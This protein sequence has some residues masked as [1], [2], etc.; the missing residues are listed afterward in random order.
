MYARL[1]LVSLSLDVLAHKICRVHLAVG[2]NGG[3]LCDL[4]HREEVLVS[5]VGSS[6]P[7]SAAVRDYLLLPSV[8]GLMHSLMSAVIKVSAVAS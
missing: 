7:L 8:V 1:F 2:R 4:G 5:V 3:L 6:I